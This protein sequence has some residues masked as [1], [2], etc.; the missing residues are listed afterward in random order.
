MTLDTLF[1]PLRR[2]AGRRSADQIPYRDVFGDASP[3]ATTPC[4]NP[5]VRLPG[6][7][8]RKIDADAYFKDVFAGS[9]L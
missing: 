5:D 6:T 3:V 4:N 8:A 2:L 1:A 7:P 9:A